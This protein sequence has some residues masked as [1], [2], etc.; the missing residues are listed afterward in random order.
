MQSHRDRKPRELQKQTKTAL[1]LMGTEKLR[2]I[3]HVHKGITGWLK[4]E[5][6]ATAAEESA[7]AG[8]DAAG[9]G[10]E[11]EKRSMK[12]AKGKGACF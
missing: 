6:A 8:V 1:R 12:R 2:K 11:G 4:T 10:E 3:E 7:A 9:V 5:E